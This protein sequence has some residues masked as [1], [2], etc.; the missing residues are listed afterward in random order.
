MTDAGPTLAPLCEDAGGPGAPVLAS[1]TWL[2]VGQ[3]MRHVCLVSRVCPGGSSKG[4]AC[5]GRRLMG[6]SP[7]LPVRPVVPREPAQQCPPGSKVR[8]PI[9]PEGGGPGLCPRGHQRRHPE[10][11]WADGPPSRPP[12]LGVRNALPV[13][14][15]VPRSGPR[16][17]LLSGLVSCDGIYVCGF[18]P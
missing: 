10:G 9:I 3:A 1:C 11:R 8:W 16:R 5:G 4:S 7:L 13:Q 2:A 17:V 18:L 12:A 6:G 14:P 15:A